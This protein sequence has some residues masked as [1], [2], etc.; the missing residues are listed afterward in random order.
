MFVHFLSF[1]FIDVYFRHLNHIFYL[2]S[3]HFII[4]S[5][6]CEC[7]VY[8]IQT[9]VNHMQTDMNHMQTHRWTDSLIYKFN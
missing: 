5:W 6:M 9:D 2:N 8:D 1:Y 7:L 3:R 4:P